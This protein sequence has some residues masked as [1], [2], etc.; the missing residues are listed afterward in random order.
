MERKTVWDKLDPE[1]D[2]QLQAYLKRTYKIPVGTP[3]WKKGSFSRVYD[4]GGGQLLRLTCLTRRGRDIVANA[5]VVYQLAGKLM[6]RVDHLQSFTMPRSGV[7]IMETIVEHVDHIPAREWRA[8]FHSPSDLLLSL[9]EAGYDLEARG[10]IH[11]DISHNNVLLSTDGTFT[12]IDADDACVPT[13]INSTHE[14]CS[15]PII[16]TS[17]YR[18]VEFDKDESALAQLT[19]GGFSETAKAGIESPTMARGISAMNIAYKYPE[20]RAEHNMVHALVALAFVAITG[21]A[22]AST[23]FTNHV[24]GQYP[25]IPRSWRLLLQRVCSADPNQRLNIEQAL[26]FPVKNVGFEYFGQTKPER[27]KSNIAASSD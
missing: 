12:F 27:R 14:L 9:L 26:R 18:L 17:G 10:I 24:R 11:R 8:Y 21:A 7:V 4:L 2:R 5:K 3:P 19:I 22:G 25:Y 16:G 1:D 6:P 15:R 20:A 13:H 23:F